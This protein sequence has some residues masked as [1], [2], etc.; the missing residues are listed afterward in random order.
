MSVLTRVALLAAD[1]STTEFH[2]ENTWLPESSEIIWGS[3]AFFIILA[4]LIKVAV[5]PIAKSLRDRTERIAKEI[6]DA[7]TARADAEAE[8]ARVRQNLADVDAE[9]ARILATADE[10]AQ[11]MRVEGIVRN[12]TEVAE[13]EA[14]A[15]ADIA[16]LRGRAAGELQ[17]QVA[18]W[19]SAA[20]EGVVAASLDDATLQ[21][22]V[23]D[24]IAKVG[25]SS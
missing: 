14:R 7:A 2:A 6:D 8:I 11:R 24:Y 9:R 3:L 22:L 19:A 15:D 20:T 21:R 17:A 16:T 18:A 12:D 13:L 4:L 10:T 5:K 1:T 23:E 25:V